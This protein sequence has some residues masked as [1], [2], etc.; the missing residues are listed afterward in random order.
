[1]GEISHISLRVVT[2][3]GTA[4]TLTERSCTTVLQLCFRVESEI[5]L[6]PGHARLVWGSQALEPNQS[7]EE[8]GI[9]CYG[10][11]LNLLVIRDRLAVSGDRDGE[12]KVW[13]VDGRACLHTVPSQTPMEIKSI[14][15]E[16]DE[17]LVLV[18]YADGN[19]RLWDMRAS[20]C[21]R[22]YGGHV[23]AVRGLTGDWYGALCRQ[24]IREPV[25]RL[26][27]SCGNDGCLK[28]WEIDTGDCR[29]TCECSRGHV[30]AMSVDWHS[31]QALGA[32]QNGHIGLWDVSLDCG[33]SVRTFAGH[34]KHVTCLTVDWAHNRALSG[35]VDCRLRLWDLN[36]GDCIRPF[37]AK[38]GTLSKSDIISA[39]AADWFQGRAVSSCGDNTAHVWDLLSGDCLKKFEGSVIGPLCAASMTCLT[40]EGLVQCLA[41][42]GSPDRRLRLWDLDGADC[43]DTLDGHSS[44][45]TALV[46]ADWAT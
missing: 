41:I 9:P 24:S 30:L 40:V 35:S 15:V 44:A 23:G 17:L 18:G 34:S 38:G 33:T 21:V 39:V 28:L 26:A 31:G 20:E 3:N 29:M 8:I 45:V 1:M 11:V 2:L 10:A 13:D 42:T 4:V 37:I 36:S 6:K 32:Y 12:I 46:A 25:L 27:L 7:L 19:L 22:S 16:W 5:D 43:V 14:S